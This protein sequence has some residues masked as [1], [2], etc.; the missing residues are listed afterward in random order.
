MAK[1]EIELYDGLP[2]IEASDAKSLEKK[3]AKMETRPE[4]CVVR[5]S[6][7]TN[8]I[9]ERAF[10]ECEHISV[11][12][13]S[14]SVTEIE[15]Y[16]FLGCTE[17]K[18][19]IIGNSVTEIGEGAFM[20]CSSLTSVFIPASVTTI[21]PFYTDVF[22]ECPSIAE[23]S[24]AEDNPKYDSR[25]N[26]NAIIETASNML[27]KGC[28]NTIIPNSVINI[29]YSAFEGC[30]GLNS[31]TIPESVIEIGSR[32][33]AEC[34]NLI[35][36]NIPTAVT[37]IEASTF[38]GCKKLTNIEIPNSVTEILSGAFC[39]CESLTNINIP[40]SV[41]IIE[42]Q[43]FYDCKSF[44]NISIPDSVTKLGGSVFRGCENLTNVKLSNSLTEIDSSLF[45]GCKNLTSVVIPASVINVDIPR[46]N[47]GALGGCEGLTSIIVAEGNPKY[48]SR[49]NCNAIIET[50]TNKLIRGCENTVI[51]DSVTTIGK[52]AFYC[53]KGLKGIVDLSHIT[54]IE[55]YAFFGCTSVTGIKLSES[56]KSI[57]KMAFYRCDNL[58][59]VK[60]PNPSTVIADEAF[61]DNTTIVNTV[62]NDRI[63][64]R[65][66]LKQYIAGLQYYFD[67]FDMEECDGS[68]YTTE[69][70]V[71]D[72]FTEDQIINTFEEAG[73]QDEKTKKIIYLA[74]TEIKYRDEAT[75]E[76]I[77][78][79][80][81]ELVMNLDQ[82]SIRH[83]EIKDGD[84]VLY[85]ESNDKPYND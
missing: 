33:F 72:L 19:V 53:C 58:T 79:I 25:E 65:L 55:N 44:T 82:G 7:K 60:I 68:Y 43:A 4:K 18:K 49:G 47:G 67:E 35:N 57:D 39:G 11:A 63:D 5:T 70:L 45:M 17:L 32:A 85:T 21:G 41:T 15:Q 76:V 2:V 52:Y 13:I 66:T 84:K 6:A 59:S 62:D 14:D 83:I 23:I 40:N 69:G 74:D 38:S 8:K 71:G 16:A 61:S 9:K 1:K 77:K 34:E 36:V 54:E 78:A 24:V 20:R 29:K 51:P 27:I 56:L 3:L 12:I 48:D 42:M 80:F 50:S 26:C 28:E 22:L 10:E 81:E 30:I 75:D 64:D 37:V 73:W 46:Y 31:I